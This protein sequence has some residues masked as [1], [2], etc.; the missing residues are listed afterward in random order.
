LPKALG[1]NSPLPPC[2]T[3]PKNPFSVHF[4]F[5]QTQKSIS[6]MPLVYHVIR[7]KVL[8]IPTVASTLPR[9]ESEKVN[10]DAS[11]VSNSPSKDMP[12]M[13]AYNDGI[14]PISSTLW[15]GRELK[16]KTVSQNDSSQPIKSNI[17]QNMESLLWDA[18]LR[19]KQNHQ[20]RV[21]SGL[22]HRDWTDN[23]TRTETLKIKDLLQP[24]LPE[25][26]AF[27]WILLDLMGPEKTKI[28]HP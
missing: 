1:V 12:P 9:L 10:E 5:A 21:F 4:F 3:R 23:S 24:E 19:L 8:R 25:Q 6:K 14:S 20:A 13:M 27:E 2:V 16:S 28:S 17:S 18:L 22:D 26:T 7:T 15:L 11:P